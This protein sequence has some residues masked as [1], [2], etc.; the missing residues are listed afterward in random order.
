MVKQSEVDTGALPGVSTA[1]ANRVKEL[2]RK[3]KELCR[4][5]EILKLV[6]AFPAHGA[7]PPVEMMYGLVD[8]P[9]AA[10]EVYPIRA[11]LQI[12]LSA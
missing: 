8:E 10:H 5:N 7:R 2:E 11:V 12:G 1:E 3:V 6:S 9:R 4:A